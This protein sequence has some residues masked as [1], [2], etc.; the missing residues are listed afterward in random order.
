MPAGVGAGFTSSRS[1]PELP[2]D[3]TVAQTP[4]TEG[5]SL[6]VEPSP[7]RTS[8]SNGPTSLGRNSLI[9]PLGPHTEQG[10]NRSCTNRG[11]PGAW[12]A[13][14]TSPS[15]TP[16]SPRENVSMASRAPEARKRVAR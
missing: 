7:Q 1:A 4:P 11:S 14:L 5:R 15:I 12:G 16:R 8:I 3:G 6:T 10:V 13:L 2:A 9:C